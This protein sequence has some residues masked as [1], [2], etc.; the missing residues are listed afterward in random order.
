M[1]KIKIYSVLLILFIAISTS[2]YSCKDKEPLA[3]E[4]PPQE[5]F[6]TNFSD[7]NSK[8][9]IDTTMANWGY[10]VLNVGVWNTII[11]V[12]LAVPVASY[13]EAIK[14]HEPEY[15]SENTWL[16]QYDFDVVLSSYTAKLFGTL[17]NDSIYWEMY[18]SKPGDFQDFLWYEGTSAVSGT[19]GTWTLYDNPTDKQ[20][21]L[22][23]IWDRNSDSTGNIKY[24]NIVPRGPENGGYIAYGNDNN[25]DLNAWYDIYNKGKDNHTNIE[26]NTTVKNGRVKDINHFGNDL[27]QCWDESQKDVD[28][29][30]ETK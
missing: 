5:S 28:C 22:G 14:N 8:T 12:G 19:K 7:F 29:P 23:I 6:V 21:L 4:I 30:I 1:K 18:I 25:T 10:S 16:W 9:A 17:D 15:Q 11:T 27:W 20:K 26:W 24:L 2:I 13:V 3:P